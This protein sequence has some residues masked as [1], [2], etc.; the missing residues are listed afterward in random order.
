[1]TGLH[2]VREAGILNTPIG[3]TSTT[4]VGA[5]RDYILRHGMD[6]GKV[7]TWRLPVVGETFDG[8]LNDT[9]TSHITYEHVKTAIET[10]DE[11]VEQGSAGGGTGM[12]CHQFKGGTGTSSRRVSVAAGEYTVGALVQANYGRRPD[13]RMAGVLVGDLFPHVPLPGAMVD[14]SVIII[15]ATD[16]PLLPIQCQRLAK[17]ATVGLAR[18]GGSGHNSS[19]DIFLAFSTA[20]D[21]AGDDVAVSSC[22]SLGNN[23][24]SALFDAV[25]DAVEEAIINA[26]LAGKTMT[27]KNGF[28]VHGFPTEELVPILAKNAQVK[29]V[30][31]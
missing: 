22:R 10:A 14:G 20:N 27:G 13:L 16:A 30:A 17:R 5:V 28:T 15:V 7:Q 2:W 25:A 29:W 8:M 4:E 11:N 24:L 1:M 26:I 21:V 3:I 19:G 6:T 31:Q 12:M 9:S 23:S 18:V